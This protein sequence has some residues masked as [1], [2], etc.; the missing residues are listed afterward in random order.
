[1]EEAQKKNSSKQ[2]QTHS[3]QNTVCMTKI[4]KVNDFT[5]DK[6]LRFEKKKMKERAKF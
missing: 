1:V 2:M 4:R 6:Q 3:T 5:M